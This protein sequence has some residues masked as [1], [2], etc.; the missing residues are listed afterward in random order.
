LQLY[1][2]NIRELAAATQSIADTGVWYATTEK[3]DW[4]QKNGFDYGLPLHQWSACEYIKAQW[5]MAHKNIAQLWADCET[6]FRMAY[7][8]PDVWFQAGAHLAYKRKGSWIFCR[9]PSGRVLCYI[10]PKINEDGITYM[11]MDQTSHKWVR[12]KVYSGKFV[13]HATQASARDLLFQNMLKAKNSGYTTV[14]RVHDELICEVPDEEKY[15]AEAL[16]KF[17]ASPHTWCPDL[18]LAAAGY[19]T[20]LRYKKD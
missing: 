8:T 7:A 9:L 16:G 2:V 17:L 3:F 13:A 4:A 18:P 14:M 10:Q 5:R 6:A 20:N 15:S 1:R 11:N 12:T 19:E